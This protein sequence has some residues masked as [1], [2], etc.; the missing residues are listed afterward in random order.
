MVQSQFPGRH[1]MINSSVVK[2]LVLGLIAIPG[3]WLE[4]GQTLETT[5]EI[6]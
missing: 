5:L 4:I 6:N 3:L 1:V 2:H